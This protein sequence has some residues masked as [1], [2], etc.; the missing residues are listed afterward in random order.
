MDRGDYDSL[1]V[2]LRAHQVAGVGLN[3]DPNILAGCENE[4][5][6]RCERKMHFEFRASAIDYRR[7]D[8]VPLHKSPHDSRHNVAGT[9]SARDFRCQQQIAG[10]NADTKM[11]VYLGPHQ[12]RFQLH[13]AVAQMADHGAAIFL[14]RQHAGVENIFES[15]ELRDGFEPR[16]AHHFVRLP[17]CHDFSSVKNDDF[18]AQ[19]KHF[20]LIVSDKENWNTMLLV[21]LS[22]IADER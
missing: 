14:K 20:F 12:R 8:D 2:I 4:S 15:R 11:R 7:D 21:P 10:P 13:R 1:S 3:H 6:A 19:S 5:I 17:L 16:R 9:Q 22:Q 18:I